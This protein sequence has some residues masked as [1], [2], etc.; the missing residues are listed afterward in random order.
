MMHAPAQCNDMKIVRAGTT[1]L[2]DQTNNC[3]NLCAVVLLAGRL[4]HASLSMAFCSKGLHHA[5]HAYPKTR[6][7]SGAATGEGAVQT[8]LC[9]REAYGM[10]S[11]ADNSS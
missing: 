4:R 8:S 2:E 10:L 11:A 1:D 3:D 7:P 9:T 5:S 6:A